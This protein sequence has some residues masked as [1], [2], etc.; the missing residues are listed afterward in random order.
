MASAGASATA[1][2]MAAAP[3]HARRATD[4]L[5]MGFSFLGCGRRSRA[6]GR[7]SWLRGQI[8][9]PPAEVQALTVLDFSPI[10]PS[11]PDGRRSPCAAFDLVVRFLAADGV[12]HGGVPGLLELVQALAA[13]GRIDVEVGDADDRSHL[14]EHEEDR[15][16]LD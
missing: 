14:L 16:V 8:P 7:P 2:A 1:A 5:D 12:D 3:N 11:K 15:P 10:L 9:E 6:Y 4:M 13:H